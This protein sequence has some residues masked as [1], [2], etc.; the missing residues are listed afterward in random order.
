[1]NMNE[2][3]CYSTAETTKPLST[4]D[5]RIHG[6]FQSHGGTPKSCILIVFFKSNKTIQLLGITRLWKPPHII[7]IKK[8]AL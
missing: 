2:S 4:V 5:Q 7:H 8:N 6:G 3:D 1:M